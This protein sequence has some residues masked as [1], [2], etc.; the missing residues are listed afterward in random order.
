METPLL[1]NVAFVLKDE[2]DLVVLKFAL[3]HLA[4]KGIL[5]F[6]RDPR[7]SRKPKA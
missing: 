5:V 2:D 1:Y 7:A 3:E 6:D 4:E